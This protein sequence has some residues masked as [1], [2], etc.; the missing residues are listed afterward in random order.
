ML[1]TFPKSN[2]LPEFL[3]LNTKILWTR[4]LLEEFAGMWEHIS[5]QLITD[6]GTGRDDWFRFGGCSWRKWPNTSQ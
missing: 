2:Y 3:P 5:T 4:A 6:A 1:M